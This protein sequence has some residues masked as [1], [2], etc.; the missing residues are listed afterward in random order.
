MLFGKKI[1]ISRIVEMLICNEEIYKVLGSQLNSLELACNP[2]NPVI[3]KDGEFNSIDNLVEEDSFWNFII[4]FHADAFRYAQYSARSEANKS[5]E[6][7]KT[8]IRFAKES[9]Q[10]YRI[11]KFN[12]EVSKEIKPIKESYV[13]QLIDPADLRHIKFIHLLEFYAEMGVKKN[14]AKKILNSS[15]I[16][17]HE[18]TF[19]S[20]SNAYLSHIN[21][22]KLID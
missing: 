2:M 13:M 12:Y 21:S 22:G 15:I 14:I 1:K 10:N 18:N 19:D 17:S 5:S 8:F 9:V 3:C 6:H 20:I 7:Q 11:N 4:Y 16:D